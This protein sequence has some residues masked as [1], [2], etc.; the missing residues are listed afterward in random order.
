MGQFQT[1]VRRGETASLLDQGRR[2]TDLKRP[3]MEH[4]AEKVSA[5]IS[6]GRYPA[7]TACH[8]P[9][10]QDQEQTR[11]PSQQGADAI[12]RP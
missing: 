3:A 1:V 10:D 12:N 5:E 11:E 4:E 9:D 2:E 8:G 7:A 6:G